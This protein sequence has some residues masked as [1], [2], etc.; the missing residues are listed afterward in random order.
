LVGVLFVCVFRAEVE[1]LIARDGM[2]VRKG[3]KECR[4]VGDDDVTDRFVAKDCRMAYDD[5]EKVG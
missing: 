4:K 1:V 3:S 2:Q 5:N